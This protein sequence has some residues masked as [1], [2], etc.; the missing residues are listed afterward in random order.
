MTGWIIVGMAATVG[1]VWA[2]FVGL[3]FSRMR[4]MHR[5]TMERL[6]EEEKA[7]K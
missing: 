4:R 5:E 2:V 7:R 6:A 1:G 3:E